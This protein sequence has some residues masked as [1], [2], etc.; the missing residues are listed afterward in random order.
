MK[1]IFINLPV[2]DVN[3][4]LEFYQQLGFTLNPLFTF[5][6]QKCLNWGDSIFVMLQTHAMFTSGN[7][8]TLIDPKHNTIA[9]FT[10]PV[11]S[12]EA[13]NS[14]VEN[15]VKGGGTEIQPPINEGF[16]LVRNI[17]DLDGHNWGIIYL[18]LEKF[19]AMKGK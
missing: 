2:L 13:L 4:S 7:N 16:M 18:D 1:Q 9:T 17:Q 12:T 3:K 8:K 19:K 11:E 15:A 14:I 10:L 5:E 6:D